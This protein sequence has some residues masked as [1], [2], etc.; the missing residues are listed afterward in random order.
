[1]TV[2]L[3][4]CCCAAGLVNDD[5][6]I[7]ASGCIGSMASVEATLAIFTSPSTL[8]W[9]KTRPTT[10]MPLMSVWPVTGSTGHALGAVD[11]GAIAMAGIARAASCIMTTVALSATMTRFSGANGL[12]GC[13]LFTTVSCP[14]TRGAL[15]MRAAMTTAPRD[16]KPTKISAREANDGRS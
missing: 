14:A 9:M 12:V 16:A 8:P 13:M 2:R 4:R 1:M 11:A 15:G 6:T 10:G 7:G 5:F 3:R